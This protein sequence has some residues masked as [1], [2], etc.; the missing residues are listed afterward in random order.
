M[1]GVLRKLGNIVH[2]LLF[3]YFPKTI[4][5]ESN[6]LPGPRPLQLAHCRVE[7]SGVTFI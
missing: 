7:K 1:L 3:V 2:F 6:F 4:A 5:R